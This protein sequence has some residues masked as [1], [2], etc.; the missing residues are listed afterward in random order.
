MRAFSQFADPVFANP[1]QVPDNAPLQSELV[2][3]LAALD[4]PLSELTRKPT[5]AVARFVDERTGNCGQQG[6]LVLS[7]AAI[8]I[9]V[10]LLL[11]ACWCAT[12]PTPAAAIRR[13]ANPQQPLK[14]ARDQAEAANRGKSVFLA[15]MSYEIRTPF[16]GL[17]ACS[18]C[19]T[20]RH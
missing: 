12:H 1:Q 6:L 15:N 5:G 9:A 16:Q 7:L 18:T 14:T 2:T 17:L 20:T 3:Q 13:T 4:T 19:S 10:M 11:S 8:Q